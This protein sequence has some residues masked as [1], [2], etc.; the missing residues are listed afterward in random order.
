MQR[1]PGIANVLIYGKAKA[2]HVIRFGEPLFAIAQGMLPKVI[3]WRRGCERERYK[4]QR[5]IEY[6]SIFRYRVA[7]L[8]PSKL[9][10]LG[11]LL[12]VR[13]NASLISLRSQ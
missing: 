3:P 4:S 8:M 1:A 2:E 6:S 5:W 9:A 13:L 7:R 12:L 10:A 11:T